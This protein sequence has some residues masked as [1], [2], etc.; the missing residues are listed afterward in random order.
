MVVCHSAPTLSLSGQC[1]YGA[2]DTNHT[3]YEDIKEVHFHTHVSDRINL[4]EYSTYTDC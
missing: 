3:V 4:I 1:H 2:P